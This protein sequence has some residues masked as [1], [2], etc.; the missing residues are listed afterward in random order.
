LRNLIAGI[1]DYFSG[2]IRLG[3][4]V[5]KGATQVQGEVKG[6]VPVSLEWMYTYVRPTKND[7]G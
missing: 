2:L 5:D 4:A 6:S 3:E 1:S 7:R